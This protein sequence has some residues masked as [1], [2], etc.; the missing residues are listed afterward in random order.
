M[1]FTCTNYDEVLGES[2]VLRAREDFRVTGGGTNASEPRGVL[3]GWPCRVLIG[4][5]LA[6]TSTPAET[7]SADFNNDGYIDL[8][9]FAI[10]M[11]AFGWSGGR[12]F[13]WDANNR[14]IA[15]VP[16]VP[17]DG[18]S[19]VEY[20]YDAFGRKV[21]RIAYPWDD[22]KGSWGDPVMTKFVYDG[23]RVIME[24]DGLNGDA[25]IRKHTW[26]LDLS[27][28]LE[29]AGGIG[30]LLATE[31]T[32]G[33]P[34]TTTDDRTFIYFYDANGNVG[35]LLDTTTGAN[36]G[37]IAAH[38]EYA[39]YGERIN[40]FADTY[41]QPFRF[42]TKWFDDACRLG[43]WG[44][45]HYD[46]VNG[47]WLKRD[48]AGYV[49]GFNLYGYVRSEPTGYVDAFGL[50]R[51]DY[52]DPPV[53]LC[54]K[55]EICEGDIKIPEQVYGKPNPKRQ[56]AEAG[57]YGKIDPDALPGF[58]VTFNKDDNCP[59]C[60]KR[61]RL[62]QIISKEGII[63]GWRG[64]K[65]D[66]PKIISPKDEKYPNRPPGMTPEGKAGVDRS[67]I[68][69]PGYT[70]KLEVCAI[71]TDKK[72]GEKNLGCITFEWNVKDRT[73]TV[74][75]KPKSGKKGDRCWVL[76]PSSPTAD[77][78]KKGIARWKKNDPD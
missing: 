75:G 48:P 55:F 72:A 15:V 19:K 24:L 47:R 78:W 30:G 14:L 74:S 43:Y 46:A 18:D 34:G 71:C 2:Y 40:T 8:E 21:L 52:V 12:K 65:V 33:T 66:H 56:E 57:R 39:P 23:W 70:A 73:L 61:I 63:Y 60:C 28:S 76:S 36:Y 13:E 31:D 49:D 10:F 7:H 9:D 69:S 44:Y 26:G 5:M 58:E 41:D 16:L 77:T 62:V 1:T 25:V 38:Y 45:R 54:G 35:Q 51:S 27:G 22:G 68:D 11:R 3:C 67:Y 32:A 59:K 64:H 29:G 53:S 20:D 4:A 6:G 50:A 37:T 17:Q 42:S